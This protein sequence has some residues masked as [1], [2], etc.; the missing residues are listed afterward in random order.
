MLQLTDMT[1]CTRQ[2]QSHVA[3]LRQLTHVLRGLGVI[4]NQRVPQELLGQ[5]V[6]AVLQLGTEAPLRQALSSLDC[7]PA[8]VLV[9]PHQALQQV[10]LEV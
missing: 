10:H 3:E 5:L 2:Q 6:E 8:A 4:F 7:C 9:S 1:D